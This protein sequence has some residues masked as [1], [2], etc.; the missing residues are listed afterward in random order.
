MFSIDR[1]A[2]LVYTMGAKKK[3]RIV[4]YLMYDEEG[5][6]MG[7]LNE[8]LEYSTLKGSPAYFFVKIPDSLYYNTITDE[9]E[10][11]AENLKV[12]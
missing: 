11:P 5:N 1:L 4:M 7:V 2:V 6:F 12:F 8:N 3:G 10:L 9:W